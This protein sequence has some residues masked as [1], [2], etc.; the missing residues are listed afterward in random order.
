MYGNAVKIQSLKLFFDTRRVNK[1]NV[2]FRDLTHL[3]S[4]KA[5]NKSKH[6]CR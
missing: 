3:F 5:G 4:K 6:N 2:N 1:L